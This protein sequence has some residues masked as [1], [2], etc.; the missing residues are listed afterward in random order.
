YKKYTEA[1]RHDDKNAILY[2]N[3]AACSLGLNRYLD[4]CT[5][6]EKAT[7]LDSGYAKAWSRLAAARAGLN[8][9]DQAVEA[10]ER[11]VAA[12]PT[13]N[14]TAAQQKQRDQYKAELAATK[15]KLDDLLAHPREPQGA[16]RMQDGDQLPWN[17]AAAMLP[18]LQRTGVWASSAWVADYTYQEWKRALSAMKDGR[19]I[20]TSK[21]A[22][23]VGRQGVVEGFTN[24]L[25]ADPRVFHIS[26]QDFL[27]MYNRQMIFEITQARAWPES[28]SRDVMKQVPERLRTEGW[29]SVRPALSL[30]VRGWIM[31]AFLE[32]SLKNNIV[33][34][35]DFYT[36]ALEVL[37]WGQ[38]LYKDVPFSE[39]GQIFQPTFIRGVKSLRL[40]AFMKVCLQGE[41]RTELEVLLSEL[42]AGANELSAEIGTVPDRPNHECIGFYLAFFPYAAGQA[43]ALR[44]FYYHQTGMN[45]EKTQGF[46]G[47]VSELYIRAGSEYKDAALKYY[48]M[49]D[50]HHPW[51]LYCAFN[52]YY[53]GGAPARDILDILDR[54]KES[55]PR[56]GRIWEF[57]ANASAGRDQALMQT[58]AFRQQLL[59]KIA[60]GTVQQQDRVY[61]PGKSP[62]AM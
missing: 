57:T 37:Q 13:D 25:I 59:D 38:E 31:R 6:A 20:Y 32:D 8:R 26:D 43:H 27:N 33:T 16:V 18:E 41:P 53:D 9:P 30:T 28:G 40:D 36:S 11:A 2:C 5:D 3:R 1:L 54:M 29:D 46:T 47:E 42:L 45:L 52:S 49:D 10:W 21:G 12:F 51:F 56:M 4:A 19:N 23:Y 60:N 15:A 34:A 48:P 39:K 7:E 35:L 58:L 22:G 24:A 55:I 14:M 61:R 44:G 62:V 50:E 17:R